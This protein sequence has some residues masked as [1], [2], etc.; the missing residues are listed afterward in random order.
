MLY[1]SPPSCLPQYT[2]SPLIGAIAAGNVVVIKASSKCPRTTDLMT[3]LFPKYLDSSAYVVIGGD[4][5]VGAQL[6]RD[7]SFDFVFFTGKTSTGKEVMKAAAEKLTP[8]SL[9][10]GGKN[11]VYVDDHCDVD[12]V[13]L[14]LKILRVTKFHPLVCFRSLLVVE[15][16][17]D[18]L[19]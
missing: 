18:R 3:R 6:L 15:Q 1:V 11:P 13:A 16:H 14:G 17:C 7:F 10:L 2:L 9:Q 5:D 19:L 8:V 4:A 12:K